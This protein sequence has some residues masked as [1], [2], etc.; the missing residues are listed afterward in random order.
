[1]GHIASVHRANFTF[2]YMVNP[3]WFYRVKPTNMYVI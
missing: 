3:S 1:M 2:W